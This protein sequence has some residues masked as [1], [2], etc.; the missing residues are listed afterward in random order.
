MYV[1]PEKGTPLGRRLSV[2]AIACSRRSDSRAREK[3]SRKRKKKKAETRGGKGKGI[4]WAVISC[5]LFPKGCDSLLIVDAVKNRFSVT[6]VKALIFLLRLKNFTKYKIFLPFWASIN[7]LTRTPSFHIAVSSSMPFSR[8]QPV[9]VAAIT[10]NCL[11]LVSFRLREAQRWWSWKLTRQQ[12]FFWL[13]SLFVE[14]VEKWRVSQSPLEQSRKRL[15]LGER[16]SSKFS[17]LHK[18]IPHTW[19]ARLHSL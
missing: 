13:R 14:R 4:F 8:P 18:R 17:A 6:S 11:S 7:D 19:N 2:Q 16:D 9:D 15:S 3:N 5:G 12:L 1:T 10:S